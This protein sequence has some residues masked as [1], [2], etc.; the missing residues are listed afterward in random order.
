MSAATAQRLCE[1]A[2]GIGVRHVLLIG[3][4]PTLWP[5]LAE[6][7]R[8]CRGRGLHTTLVTNAAAFGNDTYW[9]RYLEAP[10]DNVGVSIKAA[11]PEQLIEVVGTSNFSLV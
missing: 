5:H 9:E 8:A 7:N 1:I 2:Q 4:E 3:G 6:T 10:N 11:S